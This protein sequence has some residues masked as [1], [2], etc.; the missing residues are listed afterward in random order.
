MT[1]APF[2][3]GPGYRMRHGN[4]WASL[5]MTET[6]MDSYELGALEQLRRTMELPGVSRVT[7]MPDSHVGYGVPIG[8]SVAS[9]TH[10]YPD[11][12]G[13]DPACSVG[14]S[15]LAPEQV[16][17][18]EAELLRD[19]T[20]LV[21]VGNDVREEKPLDTLMAALNGELRPATGAWV[22]ATAPEPL[23]ARLEGIIRSTVTSRMLSQFMTIG[24]GNHFL[25]VEVDEDNTPWLVTHFGTRGL[26]AAL[27]HVFA[28]MIEEELKRWNSN[29]PEG[30]L[31]I[32]ADSVVGQLYYRFNLAMLELATYSHH[33]IHSTVSQS[34]TP[35]GFGHV[36][37]NYIEYV[38]GEY[39]G[40]KG[41]IPNYDN[42]GIP[43]VVLGNMSDGSAFYAPGKGY[44]SIAH[45]AGRRFSRGEANRR[46]EQSEV[47]AEFNA[48]GILGN[49][50]QVPID[51][52]KGAYKP[53][54]EVLQ[55]L[56]PAATLIRR[57]RP[58]MVLK[59]G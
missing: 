2:K 13:V 6:L 14:V 23:D 28:A 10:L 19:L 43:L 37:H 20:R 29:V 12:V 15:R 21:G 24:G 50:N 3:A 57:T 32:P 18:R 48:A 26:G 54:D 55:A 56:E 44:D 25:A 4:V 11:T 38:G 34:S 36:P 17:G 1:F 49:F 8:A 52:S 46:M 45:G 58:V 42:N 30:L 41:V 22:N 47:D 53:F 5:L 39:I 35:D 40:R 16:F 33:L 27:S 59:G 9:A 31:F 51:E 7:V